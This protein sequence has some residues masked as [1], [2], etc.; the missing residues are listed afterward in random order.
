MSRGVFVLLSPY[1]VWKSSSI[2]I[3]YSWPTCE[4]IKILWMMN[5]IVV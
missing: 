1:F 2:F 5:R 3:I 4:L